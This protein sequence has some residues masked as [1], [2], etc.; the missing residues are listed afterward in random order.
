MNVK[1]S[2]NVGVDTGKTQLDI[3]VRPIDHFFTV[4]NNEK[5]IEKAIKIIQNE[6]LLKQRDGWKCLLSSPAQNIHCL[7]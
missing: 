2:V 7:S 5:G 4:E 1:Q 6:S 3:Y